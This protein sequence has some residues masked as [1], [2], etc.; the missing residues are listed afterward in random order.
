MYRKLD[1]IQSY[2]MFEMQG[3]EPGKVICRKR[4]SS[5]PVVQDL[6]KKDV[7]K[8]FSADETAALWSSF[9]KLDPP[10][11]NKEKIHDIY[12][13]VLQFV[14]PELRS[15]PLYAAPDDDDLA[16]VAATKKARRQKSSQTKKR[17]AE[18]QTKLSKK[19]TTE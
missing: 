9:A 14:P 19:R 3:D 13:K 2:Q 16:E 17:L 10:P 6:L 7:A 4:P 1:S 12:K 18:Q 11:P 5:K 15:D 8:V